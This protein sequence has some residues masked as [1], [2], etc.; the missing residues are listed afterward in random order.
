MIGEPRASFRYARE[1]YSNR[2]SKATESSR[3]Q[4]ENE[5]QSR[6]GIE[7]IRQKSQ[8]LRP[9]RQ[10]QTEFELQSKDG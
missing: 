1:L 2:K 6:V 3:L 10:K 9:I 8:S 4:N 5:R 7:K